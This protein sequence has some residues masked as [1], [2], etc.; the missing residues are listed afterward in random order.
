MA[1]LLTGQ[2][3]HV[4]LEAAGLERFADLMRADGW[5]RARILELPYAQDGYW[6]TQARSFEALLNDV[7]LPAG[8]QIL[9]VGANT[10]WASNQFAERGLRPIALD[11]ATAEMQG[12]H[13]ADWWFDARDVYFE[14]VLGSMT[15]IPLADETVDFVFCCE[16]LHHNDADELPLALAEAHRVLRPGGR[17]LVINETLRTLLDRIGNHAAEAGVE[18]FD[19]YEHAHYAWEY[20]GAARRAG[21]AVRVLEPAYRPFFADRGFTI[22]PGTSAKG[23]LKMTARYAAQRRRSSRAAFLAWVSTVTPRSSIGF[24]GTKG[25]PPSRLDR[26]VDRVVALSAA[27]T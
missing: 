2:P 17:L 16:V 7:D 13:T 8:A 5:D 6:F 9:D 14:R 21:F 3:E 18:Q 1:H 25:A 10:C 20:L 15:A 12:L 26:V 11:I 19:G 23:A 4:D 24:I 22:P 27:R